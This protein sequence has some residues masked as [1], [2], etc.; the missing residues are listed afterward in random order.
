MT[1]PP[2]VADALMRALLAR[3]AYE[4]IAGDLEEWWRD[5]SVSRMRYWRL[6][7]ASIAA[8]YRERLRPEPR[9]TVFA[10]DIPPRKGDGFMHAIVKDIGLWSERVRKVFADMQVIHYG[11]T[12]PQAMLD[13]DAAVAEEFDKLLGKKPVTV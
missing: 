10:D 1:R 9:I 7:L 2:R 3:E 8:Y 4:S 5:G 12:D 6:A 13:H 11:D